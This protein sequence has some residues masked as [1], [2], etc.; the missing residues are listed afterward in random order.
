MFAFKSM[1]WQ[2]DKIKFIFLVAAIVLLLTGALVGHLDEECT[3]WQ[4]LFRAASGCIG[5]YVVM[6]IVAS[7][8]PKNEE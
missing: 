4:G 1:S 7:L 3:I 5:L 6:S 2:K 8:L